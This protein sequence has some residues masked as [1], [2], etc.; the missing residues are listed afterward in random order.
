M[1]ERSS[2][3]EKNRRGR[4]KIVFKRPKIVKDREEKRAHQDKNKALDNAGSENYLARIRGL[5]KKPAETTARKKGVDSA[6]VKQPKGSQRFTQ[7]RSKI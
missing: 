7:K 3:N 5:V 2:I 6:T 1:A 4:G